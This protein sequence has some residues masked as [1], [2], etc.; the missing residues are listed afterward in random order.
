MNTG[1]QPARESLIISI[2]Y[3]DTFTADVSTWSAVIRVLQNAGHRVVCITA[4]QGNEGNRR[5][6]EG[7]MPEGVCVLFAYGFQ[8]REF[9][10]ANGVAVDIWIDD[11]PEAIPSK[12]DLIL[13]C[14]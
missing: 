7:D 6:V 13:M 9:A 4:R 3:D 8:K 12:R 14:D 2:D 10:K 5:Q 1:I 11:L